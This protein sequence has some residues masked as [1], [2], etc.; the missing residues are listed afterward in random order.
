MNGVLTTQS[1][2]CAQLPQLSSTQN[3]KPA[4]SCQPWPV[5]RASGFAMCKFLLL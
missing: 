5:M 4:H 2:S 1:H 3:I